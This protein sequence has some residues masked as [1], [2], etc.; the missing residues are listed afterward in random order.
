MARV[1]VRYAVAVVLLASAYYAL[2]EARLGLVGSVELL[3]VATIEYGV[4]RWRPLRAGVWHVLAVSVA[5]LAIGDFVFVALEA[6]SAVPVPYPSIADIFYIGAY[7][8]LTIALFSLGQTREKRHDETSLIDAASVT[9]AGSLVAWILVVRPELQEQ[10]LGGAALVAAVGAWVG[11]IAVLSASM[12]LVLSWRRNVSVAILSV[13]VSAF[14]ISEIFYAVALVG[15]TWTVGGPVDLGY[16][17]FAALCGA[18]ALHPSMRD[19]AVPA[20]AR[21]T[22]GPW[23]LTMIAVALLVGPTALLV[24]TSTGVVRTAFAIA[25]I[26]GLV[27]IL[28]LIRLSISVRAYQRRAASEHAVRLAS[29]AMVSAVTPMDVIAGT[30]SALR[31]VGRGHATLSVELVDPY[32]PRTHGDALGQGPEQPS[33]VVPA[34]PGNRGEVAIPLSGS[35]AALVYAAPVGELD[36]LEDLLRSLADQ[37]ALA[38]QRI[39][40]AEAAGAEERDRYFRTLVLTSTDVILICRGGHIEYAT[41]SAQAMFGREVLGERFDDIVH[42]ARPA[43]L[44]PTEAGPEGPLWPDTTG[45]TEATITRPGGD[46]T[47]LVQRRDLT[48]DS[49]VRGV[50]TT[51]RDVTAE[52]DLQRDLAYRATHDELTGL[53]NVRAWGETLAAEGDRRRGP[54][55]GVAVLFIDLD[56]FKNVNDRHGHPAGDAVLTEVARRIQASMRSG[57]R[58]ARIGGDEFAIL[59]RG[60]SGVEDARAAARRLSAALAS[61]VVLDS[62]SIGCQASIGLSY[63]EGTERMRTLVRQADTALYAAKDQGKGRWTEHNPAQRSAAPAT[64]NSPHDPETSPTPG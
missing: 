22:L 7:L 43:E 36:D 1:L 59:L 30:Q 56:D 50:V 15:G 20:H 40:L 35:N 33:T 61:P 21:P 10:G 8:P 45:G 32:D 38:L 11:Y 3:S 62:T 19:L 27:S 52:R 2:P 48:G 26:T 37:A 34:G 60:L 41:P 5:L 47:V 24:Q 49:T 57:D 13:A 9:L 14:L 29:Q 53:A 25:I 31:A 46:L 51:M 39:R 16:I 23:R 54:G 63:G 44:K 17:A 64:H 55:D 18:S 58:A 42:P 28:M 4:R 6:R 12:R